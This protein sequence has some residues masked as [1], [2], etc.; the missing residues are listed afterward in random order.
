MGENG[1]R[2][3]FPVLLL[4]L[5]QEFFPPGAWR[6]KSTAASENAHFKW[7]LPILAPPVPNALPA[8]VCAHFTSRAYEANSW[9][10]SNLVMS[11]I[12]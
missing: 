12:S 7:T 2:L 10:R 1:Q 6:K 3:P 9:T 4:D 5:T 8:D 11:W